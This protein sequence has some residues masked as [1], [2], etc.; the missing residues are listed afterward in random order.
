[1][2]GHRVV[3]DTSPTTQVFAEPNGTMTME[4][5]IE[6]VRARRGD[7]WVPIDTTLRAVPGGV[8]PGA[9]AIPLTFS[10][11]GDGPFATFGGPGRQI[12]LTWPARLPKP[13]LNGDTATYPEVAPG[14]DLRV[15]ATASGFTHSLIVKRRTTIGPVRIG[16]RAGGLTVKVDKGGLVAVDGGNKVVFET[17]VPT[18]TDAKGARTT[19]PVALDKD[20]LVLSP[21]QKVLDDPATAYPV[22]IDPPWGD[23]GHDWAMVYSYPPALVNNSYWGGDGDNIAKAGFTNQG[24]RQFSTVT[25]RS[26]FQ[27]DLGGL[28][29]KRIISAEF[30]ILGK[31][32][33][34]CGGLFAADQTFPISRSTTGNNQPA[35]IR[36]LNTHPMTVGFGRADCN[37]GGL[38]VGW[39]DAP[40][41][42]AVVTA[43]DNNLPLTVRLMGDEGD[44]KAWRKYDPGSAKVSITYNSVP[45][46]PANLSTQPRGCAGEQYVNTL[47]PTLTAVP[48]DDDAGDNDSVEYEWFDRANGARV[49]GT[50]VDNQRSDVESRIVIPGGQ[51]A[52]GG[53]VRWHTRARDGWDTSDWSPDCLFTVDMKPPDKAPI[54]TSTFY[55]EHGEG[56]SP[57]ET[58][59]VTFNA[60]GVADAAEFVYRLSGGEEHRIAAVNG[61]ATA[62]ITPATPDPYTLTVSTVDRAG[63]RGPAKN[64]DFRVG[65]AKSPVGYWPLDGSWPDTGFADKAGN[66]P[67]TIPADKVSWTDGR[68]RD[69]L[70]LTGQPGSSAVMSNGPVVDTSSSFTVSAWVRL[71]STPTGGRNA[72][73]VSQ[74]ATNVYGF[75]LGYL[76]GP[77]Q[78][79]FTMAGVDDVHTDQWA[80][81]VSSVAPVVGR[82]T[83]LVGTYNVSDSKLLLYVDGVLSGQATGVTPMKSNGPLRIG[84]ANIGGPAELWPGAVD[85]VTVFD[86]AL[87]DVRTDQ[88]SEV[89]KLATRPAMD[90]AV[91]TM[92]EGSGT[93]TVDVSG[94]YAVGKISG[95][96]TWQPGVVG[97][98]AL[99]F[100]GK[101]DYITTS[102]PLVRNDNS[103]TVSAWV[104]PD[105]LDAAARTV[106]SEETAGASAFYLSYRGDENKWVFSVTT[107]DAPGP[108]S[109]SV[110]APNTVQTGEWTHLTGV[111]D[112]S[113]PEIRMY[114]NGA[115][116]GP[117]M[118]VPGGIHYAATGPLTIGRAKWDNTQTGYW[119]GWIDEVHVSSGVR[120][121]D[122]IREE[123]FDPPAHPAPG[124][125][126][127]RYYGHNSDHFT[128][129][130]VAPR[131]SRMEFAMGYLAPPGTPGTTLL[132]ECRLSGWDE[133]TSR[134]PNCEGQPRL[135]TLGA[136]YDSPP[137]GRT[138]ATL[139][140]CLIPNN[141]EHFDDT[142]SKCAG[143]TTEGPLGFLTTS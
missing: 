60:N 75:D 139:Y 73:A 91:F 68:V 54:V 47:T 105:R 46:V 27:F 13:V 57:G 100:D 48:H 62:G 37:P 120:T 43:L 30:D 7:Q 88:P 92:D 79:T 67:G 23:H 123:F 90:E 134:D 95:N 96:P 82:W 71:D 15:R 53:K 113:V 102:K 107:S 25:A 108:V 98:G 104:I 80:H 56:G 85:E 84:Q 106:I 116:A 110:A 39:G 138:T 77:N 44:W 20:T 3:A 2:T 34:S 26:F 9:T 40:M 59:P 51:L 45:N 136:V 22:D 132:Y 93:Q 64:Y 10:G 137:Q 24:D 74:D 127:K 117:N 83:H 12:A 128:T 65:V 69:A 11:G 76:V 17:P 89:D 125:Q 36:T 14:A 66:H 6:P 94:G 81:A 41:R 49:S 111:Y 32:S 70:Q 4:S 141:G 140:R 122:Q 31:F 55:P 72:A 126:V 114:V 1:M 52:D 119:Q 133:F 87:P 112:A 121:P 143:Y 115:Q 99:Q 58:G 42:D 21:D 135:G 8:A 38:W 29:G 101:D 118:P 78:W 35:V 142:D 18:M 124:T 61:V 103:Y 28:A 97:S 50:T 16:L 19:I 86:R 33:A 131:N 130:G 63:N 129:A 109:I 5:H